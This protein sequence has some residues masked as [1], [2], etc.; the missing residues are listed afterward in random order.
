MAEIDFDEWL[1]NY[2]P[3]EIKFYA[4]FNTA[5]GDVI[6]IY[7]S[8]ALPDNVQCVEIDHETAHLINEGKISLNSCFVDMSSGKFEIAEI[9][10]LTKIDDVL[11]RIIDKS[12]AGL[13]EADLMV[14]RDNNSLAFELSERYK[15]RKIHWDGST[16]MTF[17]VT[18]YNDPNVVR[19]AIK[20]TVDELVS[21]PQIFAD[22]DLSK[23]F[24]IYTKRLFPVY[25]FDTK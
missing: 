24:S 14:I 8:T 2:K 12:Y 19:H 20:F 10:R 1:A 17:L 11:H 25:L 9:K 22:L 15:K 13:L 18:E 5:T 6:G 7:P 4:A 21:A 16:E 23:K 3:P